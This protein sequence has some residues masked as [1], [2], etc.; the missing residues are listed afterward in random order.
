MY[1]GPRI[2]GG[3]EPAGGPSESKEDERPIEGSKGGAGMGCLGVHRCMSGIEG[4]MGIGG[5]EPK[6]G[7]TGGSGGDGWW[8]LFVRSGGSEV[9]CDAR[10][11]SEP[12]YV[13]RGCC[14]DSRDCP[15]LLYVAGACCELLAVP[16][17]PLGL[18]FPQGGGS[19]RGGR[20]F[21]ELALLKLSLERRGV[22]LGE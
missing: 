3:T 7:G 15:E 12:L 17:S 1:T 5:M 11:C 22:K 10:G 6:P 2:T 8:L 4:G 13:A 20:G 21:A 19:G 16:S 18:K 9:L 14:D